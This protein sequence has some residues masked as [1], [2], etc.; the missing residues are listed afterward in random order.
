MIKKIL[1][2]FAIF[3]FIPHLIAF[4]LSKNKKLIIS[5]L[6]A[7]NDLSSNDR[8]LYTDLA[9]KLLANG[10]FRTLFYFRLGNVFSKIL[11]VFY[12]RD[13]T[14][15]ID[16]RTKIGKSLT[17]AH[18]FST[19]LN[20]ESIGDNVYVNHLVTVGEKNGLRPKIGNNVE[21]H[22]NATVIGGVTIGDYVVVGAGAVVVKDIP[23]HSVVVGNPSRI[24][25]VK[26]NTT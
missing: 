1:T 6:Y 8:K 20:A 10:F 3:L 5:D 9:C 7:L 26:T 18:P 19:I 15:I 22:A 13:K 12:P 11:R 21:L 16:V 25:S 4:T 14:F 24:I 17:L 23:P 2:V